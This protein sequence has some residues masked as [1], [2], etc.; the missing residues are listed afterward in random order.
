MFNISPFCI[1]IILREIILLN[2]NFKKLNYFDVSHSHS[3]HTLE[4]RRKFCH[5][6]KKPKVCSVEDILAMLSFRRNRE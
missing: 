6:P 5:N 4:E 2:N 1:C 3:S